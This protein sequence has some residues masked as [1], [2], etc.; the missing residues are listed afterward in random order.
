LPAIVA[1]STPSVGSLFAVAPRSISGSMAPPQ[2]WPSNGANA[3]SLLE[4]IPILIVPPSPPPSV[5]AAPP[6]SV[7]V[8]SPASSSSSPPHAAAID[9]RAST[10]AA[11][12]MKSR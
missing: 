1:P 7:A 10:S 8:V 12:R 11:S 2:V 9:A 4:K 3:P 6:V 5:V